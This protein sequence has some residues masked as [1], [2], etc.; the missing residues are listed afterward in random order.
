[1]SRTCKQE[2]W[3]VSDFFID[4]S[5]V[6]AR[7]VNAPKNKSIDKLQDSSNHFHISCVHEKGR[8]AKGYVL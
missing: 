8:C 3:R 5:D 4:G 2:L 6:L 7:V 1:V